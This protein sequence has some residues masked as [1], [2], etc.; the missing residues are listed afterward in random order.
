MTRLIAALA[1]TAMLCLPAD[2]EPWPPFTEMPPE[3]YSKPYKGKLVIINRT[4]PEI[5][6]ICGS[7]SWACQWFG[8]KGTCFV[9]MTRIGAR[10]NGRVVNAQGYWGTFHH[11]VNGHCARWGYGRRGG[12]HPG[13]KDL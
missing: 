2:A 1:A 3:T 13:A 9:A 5:Q 12:D 4:F 6:R 8:P 11:E 7:G 10:V